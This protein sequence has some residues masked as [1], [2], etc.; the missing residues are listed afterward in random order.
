[1]VS[2]WSSWFSLWFYFS[3]HKLNFPLCVANKESFVIP[4]FVLKI[5][6][7][8][9]SSKSNKLL[10]FSR[11]KKGSINMSRTSPFSCLTFPH[12]YF[13]LLPTEACLLIPQMSR[14]AGWQSGL[15]FLWFVVSSYKN[16]L[17]FYL[18]I[19]VADGALKTLLCP[20]VY[21]LM[22]HYSKHFA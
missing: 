9:E 1:M 13:H 3:L 10:F 14:W 4:C 6:L 19:S 8:T 22:F 11:L 16:L 12:I 7:K 21:W 17:W 15:C 20:T 2:C 5:S 18:S